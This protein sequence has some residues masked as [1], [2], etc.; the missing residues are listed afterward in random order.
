[1]LIERRFGQI[2]VNGGELFET[3][4]VGAIGA[5]PHTRFLHAMSSQTSW[6]AF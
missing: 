4:F 1:M 3:E 2:P 5:V 6:A